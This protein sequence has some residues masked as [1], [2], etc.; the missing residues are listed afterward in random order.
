MTEPILEARELDAGYGKIVIIQEVSV[1]LQAG[2]VVGI[3]GPNGSGKSTLVKA[4]YGLAN[5]YR[6]EVYFNGKNIIQLEP[7]ERTALGLGYVPQIDNIFP[8]L[9]VF[10][11]LEMGAYLLKDGKEVKK[12]MDEIYRMFPNLAERRKEFASVL[13]GG[14]K[15]MLAIARALMGGPQVL[16]L[17]EPT[18][19]LA[20][21][22]IVEMMKK[23]D[24]IRNSGVSIVLVEQHAKK[25]LEFV[26]RAYVLVSGRKVLEG[27]GKEILNNEEMI[28]AYLG[29]R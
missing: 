18:A 6:G 12:R 29:R 2:E 25:A 28:K 8:D 4:I 3:I 5:V 20:P 22:V 11:N 24:E 17:D 21:K 9:K 26:D 27:T 23:I 15:Q 13:S 19:G 16:I 14:E 1:R 10:E 7:Q